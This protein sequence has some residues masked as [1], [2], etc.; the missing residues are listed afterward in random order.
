VEWIVWDQL[1]I[2]LT[3][4]VKSPYS[5]DQLKPDRRFDIAFPEY[6]KVD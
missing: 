1:N 4:D 6:D 2:S 5:D 3:K